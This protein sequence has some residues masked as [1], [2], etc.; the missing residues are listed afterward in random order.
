[1]MWWRMTKTICISW[2]VGV[3]CGVGMILVLQQENR[4]RAAETTS[5]H[6]PTPTTTGMAPDGTTR[7]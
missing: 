5:S 7:D 3:I 4:M 6:L 2:F 1:M